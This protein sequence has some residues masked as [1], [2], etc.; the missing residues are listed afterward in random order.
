MEDIV[1]S[2]GGF[3][4]TKRGEPK[5]G[6]E[7]FVRVSRTQILE[8]GPQIGLEGIGLLTLLGLHADNE[9]R[10]CWPSNARLAELSGASV[11]RIRRVMK[12]L[13]DANPKALV[14]IWPQGRRANGKYYR[15]RYVQILDG[16]GL[17]K[18][19]R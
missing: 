5:P 17:Q 7:R 10:R 9:T 15:K 6:S 4:A 8:D 16:L 12:R 2:E 18:G 3:T 19:N 14:K 11:N 13:D 1:I